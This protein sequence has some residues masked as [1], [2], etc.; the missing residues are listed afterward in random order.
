MTEQA[1]I[2]IPDTYMDLTIRRGE[3]VATF[4]HVTMSECD[5][6]ASLQPCI[7]T[8]T[9]YRCADW[10]ACHTRQRE[11]TQPAPVRLTDADIDGLWAR[12]ETQQADMERLKR[13]EAA[14]IGFVQASEAF[15]ALRG[16]APMLQARTD[17]IEA[18]KALIAVVKGDK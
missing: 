1:V 8:A 18:E 16:H 2:V 4:F 17:L 15:M 11:N 9:A 14:A 10:Q 7:A 5:L 6:C 13:I 12:M 3:T